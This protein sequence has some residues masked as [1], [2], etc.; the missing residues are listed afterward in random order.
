M[1]KMQRIEKMLYGVVIAMIL[2]VLFIATKLDTYAMGNGISV[3][4]D[5]NSINR[6]YINVEAGKYLETA[7]T[8]TKQIFFTNTL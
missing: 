8:T 1:I 5:N 7:N 4:G 6:C 3:K 2:G